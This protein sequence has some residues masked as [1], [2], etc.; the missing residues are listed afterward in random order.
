MG[1]QSNVELG[2]EG[3]SYLCSSWSI[4]L[5]SIRRALSLVRQRHRQVGGIVFDSQTPSWRPFQGPGLF[6]GTRA[7]CL[8]ASTS[9]MYGS[10]VEANELVGRGESFGGVKD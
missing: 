8:L 5:T 6:W 9:I 4:D 10:R 3:T 1:E 2:E 7:N